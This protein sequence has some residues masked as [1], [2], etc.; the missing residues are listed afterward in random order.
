[1]GNVNEM[2]ME[3]LMKGEADAASDQQQRLLILAN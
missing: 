3:M 1:M 2:M